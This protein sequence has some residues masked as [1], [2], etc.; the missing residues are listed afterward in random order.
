MEVLILLN[1]FFSLF[2]DSDNGILIFKIIRDLFKGFI[3][4]QADEEVGLLVNLT[5]IEGDTLVFE[6]LFLEIILYDL[7]EFGFFF[8]ELFL[9]L[10]DTVWDDLADEFMLSN[11]EVEVQLI[12]SVI[13][14]LDGESISTKVFL[15]LLLEDFLFIFLIFEDDVTIVQ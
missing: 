5:D 14:E 15:F 9:I 1:S 11:M 4:L 3:G 8:L 7:L 6:T 10:E 13:T 12:S 2:Q